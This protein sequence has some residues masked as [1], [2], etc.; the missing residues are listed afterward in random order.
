MREL[1]ALLRSGMGPSG[2]VVPG[3]TAGEELAGLAGDV[4]GDADGAVTATVTAADGGVH[5]A[6]VTML[7]VAVSRTEVAPD[8]AGI[9]A[10]R[11]AG[12]L[13]ETEP[14]E[15]A[16]VPSPLAQ[17][18]VNAAFWLDGCTVRATDTPAADPFSVET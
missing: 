18:L 9:C 14:R 7:A 1:E 5:F 16:A 8:P 3:V 11:L 10:C 4:V 15:H 6:E 17:P 12:D 13:S 2:S